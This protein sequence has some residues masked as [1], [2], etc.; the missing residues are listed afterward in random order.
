ME[1]S[2]NE[3]K[4]SAYICGCVRNCAEYLLRVFSNI[5][6]LTNIMDQWQIIMIYDHS[7]DNTL[8]FL[9]ELQKRHGGEDKMKILFNP[10][11]R[12]PHRTQN[13]ANARNCGLKYI[14]EGIEPGSNKRKY[15]HNPY[16]YFI[17]IDCDDVG[18]HELDV[19]KIAPFFKRT[20]DW[21]CLTF[22]R[23]IYYDLWALSFE[24]YVVSCWNW[25]HKSIDV[26]HR[27]QKVITEKLASMKEDELFECYSA[28]NGFGIYKT[29]KFRNCFY[30]W[31]T[32]FLHNLPRASVN[33]CIREFGMVPYIRK[34]DELK[35]DCEHRAF[36]KQAR[37]T[38]GARI[39]ISPIQ[40]WKS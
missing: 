28:F 10:Y 17:W 35:E 2:T 23:P 21:D 38:N 40:I 14:Y 8:Y 25:Q 22:N 34:D 13:I 19:D 29:D 30:D 1:V 24:P 16:P 18:A 36:H 27:M 20:N 15:E 31:I 37:D 3:N 26:I 33:H 5:D 11:P 4:P 39:M 6:K 12:S 9:K 32:D 7:D